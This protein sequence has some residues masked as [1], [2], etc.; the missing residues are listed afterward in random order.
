MHSKKGSTIYIRVHVYGTPKK[1]STAYVRVYTCSALCVLLLQLLL[2]QGQESQD[3]AV[4]RPFDV[5]EDHQHLSFFNQ[6]HQS[7]VEVLVF[8]LVS[9]CILLDTGFTSEEH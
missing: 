3:F 1:G 9:H 7:V 4:P 8:D 6:V 5:V 2:K